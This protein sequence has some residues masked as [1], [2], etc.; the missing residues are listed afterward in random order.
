MSYEHGREQ[1]PSR[2]LDQNLSMSLGSS[3]HA[4]RF[5]LSYHVLTARSAGR[6]TRPTAVNV[7]KG[8]GRARKDEAAPVFRTTPE[9]ALVVACR[10]IRADALGLSRK[11][12]DVTE[13]AEAEH[14]H[15]I[16]MAAYDQ[17]AWFKREI[18][19][20]DARAPALRA[21]AEAV[22]A[23]AGDRGAVWSF[24]AGQGRFGS[25]R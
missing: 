10:M 11:V 25:A 17:F 3:F 18:M 16:A 12:W 1:L 19:T 8:Q 6:A 2:V 22:A 13:A 9:I 24:R 7:A 5:A 15:S 21:L 20:N 23:R 4:A 14:G